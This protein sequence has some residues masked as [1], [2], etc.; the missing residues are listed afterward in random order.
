MFVIQLSRLLR[1]GIVQKPE[2][3]AGKYWRLTARD[4]LHVPARCMPPLDILAGVTN[5]KSELFSWQSH[6]LWNIFDGNF[7]L[8]RFHSISFINQKAGFRNATKWGHTMENQNG[9]IR[10]EFRMGPHKRIF[11]FAIGVCAVILQLA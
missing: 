10:M 9:K 3:Q 8:S 11:P 1:S 6:F 5:G 2:G 4:S 7:S